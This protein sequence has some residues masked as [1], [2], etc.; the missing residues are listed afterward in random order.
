MYIIL[1]FG[2]GLRTEFGPPHLKQGKRAMQDSR[3][4][5]CFSTGRIAGIV[6]ELKTI[7]IRLQL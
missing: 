7:F 6:T 1:T 2:Q 5:Q 3:R 4:S